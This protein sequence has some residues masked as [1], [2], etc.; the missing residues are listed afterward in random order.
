MIQHTNARTYTKCLQW[1]IKE[2]KK[3]RTNLWR[4][5][6]TFSI[7]SICLWIYHSTMSTKLP[8]PAPFTSIVHFSFLLQA[9]IICAARKGYHILKL[10]SISRM[11]ENTVIANMYERIDNLFKAKMHRN[12]VP[13]SQRTL[14][15]HSANQIL[16]KS[17]Y[18]FSKPQCVV[19]CKTPQGLDVRWNWLG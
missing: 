16:C 14:F 4:S 10:H 11:E 15:H 13:T 7:P 12:I 19:V 6:R 18:W 9:T 3:K 17:S 8:P 5:K 2:G 1:T